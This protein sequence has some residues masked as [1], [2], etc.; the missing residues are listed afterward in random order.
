MIQ[1]SAPGGSEA[2][3]NGLG[4]ASADARVDG[5][6]LSCE[7]G[8]PDLQVLYERYFSDAPTDGGGCVFAGCHLDVAPIFDS[9]QGFLIWRRRCP[10][11]SPMW[12]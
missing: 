10:F 7:P 8:G 6:A 12:W 11:T 9:A 4:D 5:G 3:S 1:I 2:T